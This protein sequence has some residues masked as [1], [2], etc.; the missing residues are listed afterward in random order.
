MSHNCTRHLFF[1]ALSF[2]VCPF[3]SFC[4]FLSASHCW[5]FSLISKFALIWSIVSGLRLKG[6]VWSLKQKIKNG[7][8]TVI[9]NQIHSLKFS[10]QPWAVQ[11]KIAYLRRCLAMVD[12]STVTREE[13]SITGSTIS[14]LIIG[15][16]NSSGAS[17]NASS[18]CCCRSARDWWAE[19]TSLL[20]KL[21]PQQT[22]LHFLFN[23]GVADW[24]QWEPRVK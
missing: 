18:S 8:S 9:G 5:I 6:S 2:Y 1:F 14:V 11:M 15:S 19:Q 16:R 13:G 20:V 17:T 24:R 10:H 12:L 4:R 3:W 7:I 23:I 21:V 22:A